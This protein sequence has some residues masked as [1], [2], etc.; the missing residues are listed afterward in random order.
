MKLPLVIAAF[1]LPTVGTARFRDVGTAS[2]RGQDGAAASTEES[3]KRLFR[4]E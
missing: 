1:V 2:A 3:L 4:E